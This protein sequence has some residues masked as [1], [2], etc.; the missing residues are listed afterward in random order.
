MDEYFGNLQENLSGFKRQAGECKQKGLKPANN[1][2]ICTNWDTYEPSANS[3]C[4]NKKNNC[5][6]C[7]EK[8]KYYC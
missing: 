7:M 6:E 1:P 8:V 3:K 2:A 5:K 4:A